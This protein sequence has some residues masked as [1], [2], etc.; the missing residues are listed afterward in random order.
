MIFPK[1]KKIYEKRKNS[2]L[3]N[4]NGKWKIEN[5]L[6]CGNV[7]KLLFFLRFFGVFDNLFLVFL[8]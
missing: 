3:M 5:Y 4:E 8:Q 6:K 1:S 7:E 2:L